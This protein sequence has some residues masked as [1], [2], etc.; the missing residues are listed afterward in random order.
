[1]KAMILDAPG[2][3]DRIRVANID[4]ARAPAANEIR[5]RMKAGCINYHDYGVAS[6]RAPTE[7]GRILLADGAGIVEQVGSEVTDFLPGDAVLTCI[8]PQWRSGPPQVSDF[9][10]TPGDGVNGVACETFTGPVGLFTPIP[11]GYSMAEAATI[12]TAGVT[13]WRALLVNGPLQAGET[14]L[15]QGSGGV[16]LYALQ[17]A[18]ALGARVIA[19]SSSS[20]KLARLRALGADHVINYRDE[21]EWGRLAHEWTGGKGVDHVIDVGGPTTLPQSIEA[22][23]IGGHI[24]MIGLLGGLEAK[25][26]MIPIFAKQIRFQGCLNGSWQDQADLVE[27]LAT[28]D[29]RPVIDR[30]FRLEELAEAF[31]YEESG[32]HFGKIV[33]D[34]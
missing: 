28:H 4:D 30:S 12:T 31:R 6:G 11:R 22:V 26:P 29:I 1:M 14:V 16:S 9:S 20:H 19:T 5:V 18:K 23:K 34:I 10:Q 8:F 2:G 13:A 27:F 17:I 33:I 32:Q 15:V 3:L 25:I 24:A 7:D 21:P